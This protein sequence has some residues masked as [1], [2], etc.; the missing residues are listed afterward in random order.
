[1]EALSGQGRA[2]LRRL[3]V[4]AFKYAMN[5]NTVGVGFNPPVPAQS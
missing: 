2:S 4:P 5:C 3:S 1:M